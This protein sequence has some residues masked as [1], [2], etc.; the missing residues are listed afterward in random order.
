[1]SL[2]NLKDE[3]P[4]PMNREQFEAVRKRI[5]ASWKGDVLIPRETAQALV[6]EILWLKRRLL[7]VEHVLEPLVEMIRRS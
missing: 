6:D 3:K 5:H 7:R 2:G 4:E 1:M